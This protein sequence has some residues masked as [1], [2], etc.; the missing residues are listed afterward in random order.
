MYIV[1]MNF[2][3]GNIQSFCL[4]I[5]K[6]LKKNVLIKKVIKRNDVSIHEC[7]YLTV[8]LFK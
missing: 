6:Y 7:Y 1:I 8:Y 5:L 4:L 3:I 2:K